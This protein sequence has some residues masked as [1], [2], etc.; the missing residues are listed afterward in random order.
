MM[1]CSPGDPACLPEETPSHK[2]RLTKG[3]EIGRFEV[4]QLQGRHYI[5]L[6]RQLRGFA[7]LDA[8][9]FAHRAP[10]I[11]D[12]LIVQDREQ[13]SAQIGAGLP[14]MLFGDRAARQLWTRSSA[15]VTSLVSAR[16]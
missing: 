12:M 16:A 5:R 9:G 15:R 1:G 11:V 4:T 8:A 13:P 7:E 6:N 10:D 3:F 14:K 2:V